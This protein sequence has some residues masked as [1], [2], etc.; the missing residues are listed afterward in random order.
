[1]FDFNASLNDDA[2]VSP[3]SFPVEVKRK[4]KSE[5]LMDAFCDLFL[6]SLLQRLSLVSVVFD[7]NDSPNDVA[8]VSPI[9]LPVD[10][11]RKGKE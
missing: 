8:P 2:P 1:M 5:L 10:V 7:F 4:E 9:L 3:M 6:L 11:K